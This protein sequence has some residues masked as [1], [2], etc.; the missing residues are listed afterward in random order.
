MGK[1]IW[2]NISHFISPETWES[3]SK[4]NIYCFDFNTTSMN[5]S[6][7][8]VVPALPFRGLEHKNSSLGVTSVI[9]FFSSGI[10]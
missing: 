9:V 5:S 3:N 8:S 4:P 7:C 10:E 6:H 2:Q 1:N